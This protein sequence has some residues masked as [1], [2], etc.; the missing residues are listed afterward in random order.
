MRLRPDVALF[1]VLLTGSAYTVS[2]QIGSDPVAPYERKAAAIGSVLDDFRLLTV[3]GKPHTL[4]ELKGKK[5]TVLYFWS[6]GCPCVDVVEPRIQKVIE[7]Y[8]PKGVEFIA[9]DSD[10]TDI[11]AEIIHKMGKLHAPYRMLV[12][13]GQSVIKKAGALTSTEVVVL[14]AND[15]IRYRGKIDDDLRKPTIDYLAPALDAILSG[16]D[17]EPAETKSYGCPF[18][19]FE[20]VCELEGVGTPKSDKVWKSPLPPKPPK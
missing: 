13:P 10:P 11:K 7:A 8:E 19:G 14:D 17:P 5:A 9:I 16:R 4:A 15:R 3:D 1:V 20:G 2:T 18:P 12:D 6:I